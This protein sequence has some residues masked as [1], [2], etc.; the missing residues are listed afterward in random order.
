VPADPPYSMPVEHPRDRWATLPGDPP[1]L[2]R[3]LTARR[4][5]AAAYESPPPVPDEELS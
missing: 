4:E 3:W 5:Q 2:T 1:A